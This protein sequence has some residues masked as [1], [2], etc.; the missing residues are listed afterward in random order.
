MN[1]LQGDGLRADITPAE[2]IVFV[3][4]DVQTLVG[5]NSNLDATN[6]FAEIAGAIMRGATVSSSHGNFAVS[7]A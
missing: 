4:A 1:I 5:L 2:R 7:F 3:T 6:S